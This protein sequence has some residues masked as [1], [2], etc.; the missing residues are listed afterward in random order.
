MFTNGK[1][2][3]A[4]IVIQM[5]PVTST[6]VYEW[7]NNAHLTTED[8]VD[9]KRYEIPKYLIFAIFIVFTILIGQLLDVGNSSAS[10]SS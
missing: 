9:L 10:S 8:K 3:S 1:F 4:T 7:I 5:W 6:T 2:F